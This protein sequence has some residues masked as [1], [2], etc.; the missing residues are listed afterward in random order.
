MKSDLQCSLFDQ[1]DALA[2]TRPEAAG[3]A[4]KGIRTTAAEASNAEEAD[5]S[6]AQTR[7]Q[8][9]ACEEVEDREWVSFLRRNGRVP[10][11]SDERNPGNTEAG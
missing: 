10:L 5:L 4:F 11:V 2:R 3:A 7:K 9:V 8:S 1:G 6:A